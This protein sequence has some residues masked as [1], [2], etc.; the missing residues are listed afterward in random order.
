MNNFTSVFIGALISIMIMFNGTLANTLGNYSSNV[1]IHMVGFIS[2]LV[3]LLVNK[4]QVIFN[5]NIPFY[6][7]SAGAIGVFTVLFTNLSFSILG[8]SIPLALGLLGQSVASIAIDQW[9]LLGA[10]AVP[11]QKKKSVGLLF[12]ILGVIIMTLF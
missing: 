6:L 9:G 2:I 10:K 4:T 12:I 7:Y 5:G 11:F 1:I 3:I 8:V